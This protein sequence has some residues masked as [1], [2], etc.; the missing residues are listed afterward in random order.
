MIVAHRGGSSGAPENSPEAFEGAIAVR[1][2]MVEFDVRRTRDGELVIFHDE[3]VNGR[4]L[5]TLSRGEVSELAGYSV[6]TLGE[7]LEITKDR[8]RLDIELKENGYVRDVVACLQEHGVDGGQ[9]VITSFVDEV[10]KQCRTAAPEI[11]CGLLLGR[12]SPE[13]LLRTRYSEL[14]T[15]VRRLR[16]TGANFVAPHLGLTRV[17]ALRLADAAGYKAFV[18]TV[19]EPDDIARLLTDSRVEAIITDVPA[20]AIQLRSQLRADRT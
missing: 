17:G 1:A 2:D 16:A 11:R 20:V 15:P 18:W 3:Q 14:V 4:S 10:V 13:H 19:N 6:L 8:I 9:A 5:S 7:T 12:G